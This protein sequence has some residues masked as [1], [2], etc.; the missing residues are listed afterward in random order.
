MPFYIY[1]YKLTKICIS[2]ILLKYYIRLWRFFLFRVCGPEDE[3]P[4]PMYSALAGVRDSRTVSKPA[5][6]YRKPAPS[7][8][9]VERFDNRLW[10]FGVGFGGVKV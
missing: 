4:G 9:R 10:R 1:T 3:Q 8:G 6:T 5:W 2:Y 7:I